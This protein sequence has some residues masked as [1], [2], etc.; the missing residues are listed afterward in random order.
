M[1]HKLEDIEFKVI[2]SGRRSIGISVLPDSSVI[3]R[4]PYLTPLTTIRKVVTEKYGW[5]LKHRDN[6]RKPD[7]SPLKKSY[8]P[9]EK[10]LFRGRETRLKI[11]KSAKSFIRFYDNTI[12][13]GTDK[14]DDP[15]EI[16]RLLYKGYKNEALILFPELVRKVLREHGNQMFRP[17]GLVVRTMK[18]RWGSCSNKGVIT[19]S[20]ELVKLSDPYIE[21][22]I[23]HEL[24]HL[25]HHN[26]GSQ[27]YKLLSEVFPE[28]KTVRK[29]LRKYIQ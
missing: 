23:A 11:E 25:K 17:T 18:R 1:I 7:H 15:A 28:W 6:Y 9:D 21:Y 12:E 13:L 2:Y 24:C 14:T 4:V 27:Y 20:T 26:H 22:V 3:V 16:R 29:E 19:L 5:I 10:H 8:T